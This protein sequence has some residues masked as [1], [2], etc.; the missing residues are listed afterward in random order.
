MASDREGTSPEAVEERDFQEWW[1]SYQRKLD[2]SDLLSEDQA[3][4]SFVAGRRSFAGRFS[5]ALALLRE[6]RHGVGS[7]VFFLTRDAGKRPTGERLLDRAK[8]FL[9]E[10]AGLVPAGGK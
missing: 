5:E 9:A 8:D 2:P 4:A 6:Y 1:K 10:S 7:E 3:R